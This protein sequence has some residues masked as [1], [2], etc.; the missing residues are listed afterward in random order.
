MSELDKIESE[1]QDLQARLWALQGGS[2]A[3]RAQQAFLL[4]T[5]L[6]VRLEAK[7]ARVSKVTKGIVG[8]PCGWVD[9]TYGHAHARIDC[10]GI[11][12]QEYA[13]DVYVSI[14]STQSSTHGES[15]DEVVSVVKAKLEDAATLEALCREVIYKD[16]LRVFMTVEA[17]AYVPGRWKV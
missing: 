9:V 16:S 12:L 3:D 6:A 13:P 5:S 8:N 14:S 17:T 10:P 7:G 4:V 11:P 15:I 1:L 2:R